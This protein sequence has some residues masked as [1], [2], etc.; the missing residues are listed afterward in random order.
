[1]ITALVAC[2]DAGQAMSDSAISFNDFYSNGEYNFKDLLGNP[3]IDAAE[4]V[5]K[6]S[7]EQTNS[8]LKL[9]DGSDSKYKMYSCDE[10]L[11][12]NGED[13]TVE[14]TIFEDKI[15]AITF[16]K[17]SFDD[18]S[19][20]DNSLQALSEIYGEPTNSSDNSNGTLSSL[21]HRWDTENTSMQLLSVSGGATGDRIIFGVASISG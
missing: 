21:G 15:E 13:V 3:T 9:E 18:N 5:F 1:M 10:K 8:E 7:F 20:F 14:I 16:T 19:F 6:M 11:N 2:A 12:L 4:E 17:V